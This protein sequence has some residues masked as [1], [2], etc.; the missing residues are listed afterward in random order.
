MELQLGHPTARR[1][2]YEQRAVRSHALGSGHRRDLRPHQPGPIGNHLRLRHP[3]HQP[4]LGQIAVQRLT[5]RGGPAPSALR[6]CTPYPPTNSATGLPVAQRGRSARAPDK[7]LKIL[8]SY[9]RGKTYS[10]SSEPRGALL[11]ERRQPFSHVLGGREQPEM[12]GLE[13]QALFEGH[14]QPLV[15]SLQGEAHGEG[16]H[17]EDTPQRFLRRGQQLRPRHHL[18]HEADAVRL[19][20]VDHVA[21]QNEVEGI[22]LAHEARQPLRAAVPGRDAELHLGLAEL[23]GVARDPQVTR[24]GELAAAPQGIPVHRRDDWFAAGLEATQHRLAMLRPR[25]AVEWALLCEIRDVGA[26]DEG[27]GAGAREDGPPDARVRRH[28]LGGVGQLVH[29]LIVQRIDLV[30]AV[31]GDQRDRSARTT[32]DWPDATSIRATVESLTLQN[33]ARP[34]SGL[35]WASRSVA[36]KP[37]VSPAAT[38]MV[39]GETDTVATGS[40]GGGGR[41]STTTSWAEPRFPWLR[42]VISVAPGRRAR[43]M[44]DCPNSPSIL[45]TLG[46]ATIHFT[47]PSLMRFPWASRSVAKKPTLSPTGTVSDGGVTV[48]DATGPGLPPGVE[49]ADESAVA[50]RFGISRRLGPSWSLH[51]AAAIA[52][53]TTQQARECLIVPPVRSE[54]RPR[55]IP[56]GRR[57]TSQLD[58]SDCL[59]ATHIADTLPI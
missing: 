28:A 44:S 20:G 55:W 35:P 19:P 48:T 16:T 7:Q 30:G 33:T 58:A 24:H 46:S 49:S 50:P 39:S 13:Q 36:K 8:R 3:F 54:R 23:G 12:I 18:V 57:L 2:A 52:A 42:A 59:H 37:T 15:H 27:L 41:D 5:D 10:F 9:C 25:F 6:H 26:G 22:P 43:K 31:D 51:A 38:T 34:D 45:A 4:R 14:L 29:H 21:R 11:Q 56:T 32:T 1:H 40:G 53:A 47:C 17:R